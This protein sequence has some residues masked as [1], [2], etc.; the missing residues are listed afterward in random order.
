MAA[1]GLLNYA[2]STLDRPQDFE[3]VVELLIEVVHRYKT[4][5]PDDLAVIRVVVPTSQI[6]LEE[7]DSFDTRKFNPWSQKTIYE[8]TRR[9]VP[10]SSEVPKPL[11]DFF[12]RQTDK[13]AGASDATL[14]QIRY[15]RESVFLRNWTPEEAAHAADKKRTALGSGP[16]EDAA[17][18]WNFAQD[19]RSEPVPR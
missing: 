16:A 5:D 3:T 4:L 6:F 17:A 15:L 2:L 14:Q 13:Y 7:T 19:M 9:D 12:L 8:Y 18:F 1:S 10:D 11:F